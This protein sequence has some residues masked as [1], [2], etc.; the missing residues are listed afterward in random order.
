MNE[1]R[2]PTLIGSVRRALRLMEA[3]ASHPGGAPAKQLARKADLPLATA[4][5]LLRTLVHEGYVVRTA[6]GL[7]LLGDQVDSLQA[8]R[9][10]QMLLGQV[11]AALADLRDALC[12]AAYLCVYEEGEIRIIEIADGPRA[13]RVDL[14]VGLND[15]AHATAIGKCVLAQ[16]GSDERREHLA[17]HPMVDLTPNTITHA[18][19]LERRLDAS[20]AID[21][22]EYIL[23]TGCAAVPVTDAAGTTVGT[24]AVSCT[25]TRLPVIQASVARIQVTAARITRAF[26]I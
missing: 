2:R 7:Y 21:V 17:R 13:P 1:T 12:A 11:R 16:L 26:T 24:L 25:P 20:V 14:W 19:E 10:T 9:R 3:V 6:G 18:A 22:E 8:G 4:Y 15:T 23:G 5:H